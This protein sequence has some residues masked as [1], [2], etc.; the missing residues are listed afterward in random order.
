M[1]A[2]PYYRWFVGDFRAKTAGLSM[3]EQGCYRA[4][5][6]ECYMRGG[7][8]PA[9]MNELCRITGAITPSER[10]SLEAVIKRFF[11]NKNNTLRNKRADKEI[12]YRDS[13]SASGQAGAQARWNNK[14]DGEPHSESHGESSSNKDGEPHGPI[15]HIPE[16]INQNQDQ[17]HKNPLAGPAGSPAK[18]QPAPRTRAKGKPTIEA[19]SAETWIAYANAYLERYSIDPVRNAKTNSQLR[20]LI[21]RIG[22]H[23]APLVAAWFLTHNRAL[24]VASHHSIGLLLRDAEALRTE[25]ATGQQLTD[26][27]ARHTD[28]TAS[29]RSAFADL[30]SEIDRAQHGQT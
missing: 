21:Q 29:T 27:Q 9:D 24:Y 12:A 11:T 26:H 13:Q 23:E 6:D 15:V 17:T 19:A 10:Q 7:A 2:K 5:L 3:Q 25:W 1:S 30:L 16:S 22:Q 14:H 28:R 18:P 8:I 4:L 20:Q